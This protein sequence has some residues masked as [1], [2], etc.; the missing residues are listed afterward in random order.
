MSTAIPLI[1]RVN[2]PKPWYKQLWPWLIMSGPFLV[3]I[4]ASYTGWIAFT[5][6]DAMVVD[7]YYKQGNAINK[8]LRRDA[9]ATNL[10]LTVNASYDAAQGKLHGKLLSFNQPISGKIIIL[11]SHATQPE[12]DRKLETQ[13]GQSGNFEAVL[14]ALD[15]GRWEVTVENEQRNWRLTGT[16]K[17]PQQRTIDLKADLP[18]A[19]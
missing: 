6:Q 19:D 8:D 13:L 1:D 17:W 2:S 5:R 14:P 18:P 16:W 10:G 9:A 3:V 15:M 12:K 4:A 7:D 11:L